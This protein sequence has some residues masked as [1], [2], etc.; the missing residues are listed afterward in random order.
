MWVVPQLASPSLHFPQETAA[1]KKGVVLNVDEWG[2]L[3]FLPQPSVVSNSFFFVKVYIVL[4]EYWF[5]VKWY[6]IHICKIDVH[7]YC[8]IKYV[9]KRW[10][11][12][13]FISLVH[14]QNSFSG[15]KLW[16]S[17]RLW[18]KAGKRA[19]LY[20]LR[21]TGW[22]SV[23]AEYAWARE[24][25]GD[26]A[27]LLWTDIIST[28]PFRTWL[29][30]FWNY[31]KKMLKKLWFIIRK[32][33]LFA[34][35]VPLSRSHVGDTKW[36]KQLRALSSRSSSCRTQESRDSMSPLSDVENI[37]HYPEM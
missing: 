29:W 1:K 11:E 22:C 17:S 37:R 12:T 10:N 18:F 28:K 26:M 13:E 23:S 9:K 2:S 33:Q 4:Y 3:F 19:T 34:Q 7:A 32:L 30:I 24:G 31:L 27:G 20:D 25:H 6:T 14:I 8:A 36:D 5:C 15:F 16:S 21:E 35:W